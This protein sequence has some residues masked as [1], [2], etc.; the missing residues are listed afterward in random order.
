MKASM[1]ASYPSRSLFRGGQRTLLAIFCVAVGVMAVVALQLVGSMLQTSL[2][3]NTRDSNGG[4]I[5]GTTQ[6]TLFTA[7]DL[8]FFNQLQNDG[9]ITHSTAVL[10]G[11]C[12]LKAALPR[13]NVIFPSL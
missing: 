7:S 10:H 6:R 4:D 5:A 2:N 3:S 13:G 8:S 9:T 1:Y 12:S 11:K